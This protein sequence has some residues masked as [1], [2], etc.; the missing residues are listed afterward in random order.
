MT[1]AL[2]L[3][4]FIQQMEKLEAGFAKGFSPILNSMW[5]AAAKE[6][7]FGNIHSADVVVDRYTQR[8]R[9]FVYKRYLLTADVLGKMAQ[10]FYTKS[11]QV[12]APLSPEFWA[13]IER[14]GL[15]IAARRVSMMDITSKRLIADAVLRGLREGDSNAKIATTLRTIG[16]T[17][18]KVRANMIART[19][20][21]TAANM[22]TKTM[23]LNLGGNEKQWLN[24][25][26]KRV[27][28]NHRNVSTDWI[29]VDEKFNVGGESMEYPGD[30]GASAANVVNCRCTVLYRTRRV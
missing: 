26:D 16:I 1:K 17:T 18:S 29:S 20:T 19:E 10:D 22:A 13:E 8:E 9:E 12:K 15:D 24:A 14:W 23:A 11:V 30:S 6:V 7:A 27:R 5:R 4:T 21:H 28:V 25:G 2:Y 3:K